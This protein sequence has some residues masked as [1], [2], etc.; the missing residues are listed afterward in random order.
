MPVLNSFIQ[1]QQQ[2]FVNLA[3]V[4]V[5]DVRTVPLQQHAF[6]VIP[7]FSIFHSIKAV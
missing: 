4:W 2:I 7:R 1:T 6:P 5:S 3:A